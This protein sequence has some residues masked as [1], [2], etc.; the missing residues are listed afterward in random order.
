LLE[1]T[2][3]R[4]LHSLRLHSTTSMETN[5]EGENTPWRSNRDKL[6]SVVDNTREKLRQIKGQVF[7]MM[8]GNN[9][10]VRL[11]VGTDGKISM[12]R[13]ILS[14]PSINLSSI[15]SVPKRVLVAGKDKIQ[16]VRKEAQGRAQRKW[17]KAVTGDPDK[18]IRDHMKEVPQVKMIDKLSFTFGVLTIC[19]SEWL[20]L[21][22]ADWFPLYYYFIMTML[23]VWRLI[24]YSKD[25]YQLFML[26][27]CYFV[28]LSV[29]LQ[30]AFFPTDINWFKANY[31]LCM[32]PLMFAII[33]WKNSLVFHSLDKLTS[34]FL[35]AFPPL[36]VHL[37]RWGLIPNPAIE[38]DDHL[39]PME[40][41]L[42]PLGLYLVWQLG[43]WTI[44]EGVLRRQLA[45][46]PDLITSIRYLAGD[47][48]N[49]FR[50]L[51]LSLL[52]SLGLTHPGEDLDPEA[53]KTKITFAATQL[54]YTLITVIPTPFLYSS[55]RFSC[56]YLVL[57]YGFGTWNGASYYIEVF[58]E[59]YRLQF[60]RL[61]DAG[62][63]ESPSV[64]EA[65]E[66]DSDEYENALENVEIDQSSELYKTIVAAIIEDEEA[67]DNTM[68]DDAFE[69]QESTNSNSEKS[70]KN[71]DI[72]EDNLVQSAQESKLD[73]I[74]STTE[75]VEENI[76]SNVHVLLEEAA[77]DVTTK[78]SSHS[79]S[80]SN[81]QSWEELEVA[82]ADTPGEN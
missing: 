32:G 64:G 16:E 39:A 82:G 52:C 9:Q 48:K 29:A 80:E 67:L 13:R 25:K 73:K 71:Q 45:N 31:I 47:K 43:Y 12:E 72:S 58:A 4:D 18:R 62:R 14:I 59:R 66:D 27:F 15:V 21:R 19:G 74:I 28:N 79:S 44:T 6:Q 81:G 46:D 26:D 20:A 78:R 17:R 61:E 49:G 41:L 7:H 11:R 50:N 3:T 53:F 30:T 37:F 36:T 10:L 33:V 1:F 75:T 35:H 51:C 63:E 60:V 77:D 38:K 68:P 54:V 56:I 70:K 69:S 55:Y 40:V 24:T 2:S 22:H 8:D 57:L 5:S 23:L 76:N 42:L 65:S 34:F